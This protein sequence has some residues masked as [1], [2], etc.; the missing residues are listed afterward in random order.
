MTNFIPE[1]PKTSKQVPYFDDVTSEDGWV[2]QTTGK[3]TESLKSI[4]TQAI[5]RLGGLVTGFPDDG[6]AGLGFCLVFKNAYK[7]GGN[8]LA[9]DIVKRAGQVGEGGGSERVAVAVDAVAGG[10]VGA[11]VRGQGVEHDGAAIVV[12]GIEALELFQ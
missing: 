8:F 1:Q 9:V 5:S 4:I 7:F 12:V 6:L 11:F 2:G 3:S 10:V